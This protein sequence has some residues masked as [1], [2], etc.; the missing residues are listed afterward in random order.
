M[1]NRMKALLVAT[2]L[3][4]T[5]F[6]PQAFA[7]SD[8]ACAE[9]T[10]LRDAHEGDMDED[11]LDDVDDAIDADDAAACDQ[12]LTEAEAAL[13]DPEG[14][15]ESA[16]GG[17]IVV[18]QEEPDVD[19]DQPAPEVEVSQDEPDVDVDQPQPEVIV[20]QA[21]PTVTVEMP[22][23]V[24][25]ID[26]P[27]PEIIVRMPDADVDVDQPEPEIE[28]S[29][30]EP[31]V[32]IEQPQPEVDV[33]MEEP[34]VNVDDE[35]EAE[36]SVDSEQPSV[37]QDANSE[38]ADIDVSREEADV[39][40]EAAEPNVEIEEGGDAEV[41]IEQSEDADVEQEA[42]DDSGDTEGDDENYARLG[43]DAAEGDM[44]PFQISD[45]IDREVVD[46]EGD[47]VGT[48]ERVVEANGEHYF[49]LSDGGFLGLGESEVGIP[50]DAISVHSDLEELVVQGMME[51]DVDDLE[52]FDVDSAD[53]L[54]DG[55]RIDL[56][57]VES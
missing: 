7:Q 5:A 54:D 44:L 9:L 40:Y 14:S 35:D 41:R 30:R 57:M 26:Q 39:S 38:E 28:V 22:D 15:N 20:R 48:V 23:P 24:V 37:T 12:H 51:E 25:T 4:S 17:R 49:V 36:V 50:A 53:P 16:G 10:E 43:G 32:D 42:M 3:T 47:D 18:T 13:D 31:E 55:D 46:S 6:A 45:L 27:E 2:A 34:T 52:E 11:W 33:Q 19:V 29:Q 56:T 1:N 8:D 21:E